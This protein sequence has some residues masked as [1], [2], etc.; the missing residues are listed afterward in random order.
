MLMY[1]FN[2]RL[3][4]EDLNIHIQNSSCSLYANLIC[5]FQGPDLIVDQPDVNFGLVRFGT[6]VKKCITLR[7]TCRVPAKWTIGPC[8]KNEGTVVCVGV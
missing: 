2:S 1:S 4:I 7:N 6:V 5:I 8:T 3:H